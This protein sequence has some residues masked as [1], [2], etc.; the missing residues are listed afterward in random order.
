MLK[1][2]YNLKNFLKTVKKK[3]EP[4]KIENVYKKPIYVYYLP[5]INDHCLISILA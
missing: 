2:L 3:V 1:K 5:G 4:S